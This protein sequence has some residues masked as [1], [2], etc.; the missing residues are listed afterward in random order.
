MLDTFQITDGLKKG[1][2]T[3]SQ[4]KAVVSALRV[5]QEDYPTKVSMQTDIF[6]LETRMVWRLMLGLIF[7]FVILGFLLS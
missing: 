1:G 2:F 6:N 7:L 3:E 4:A 5:A